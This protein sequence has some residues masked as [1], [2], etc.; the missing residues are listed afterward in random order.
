MLIKNDSHSS[1][2]VEEHLGDLHCQVQTLCSVNAEF[3]ERTVTE[4]AAAAQTVAEVTGMG[5]IQ[6][7]CRLAATQV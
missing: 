6:Q 4:E 2:L 3:T 5:N 1:V 7:G